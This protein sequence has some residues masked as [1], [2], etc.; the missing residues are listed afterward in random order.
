[1]PSISTGSVIKK[2]KNFI[3]AHETAS[4]PMT[5][6]TLTKGGKCYNFVGDDYRQF[7]EKY[8]AVLQSGAELDLHFVEKPNPVALFL[9]DVD[10]DQKGSKRQYKQK[11]IKQIIEETNSFLIENFLVTKHQLTTFVTE[12]DHSTKRDNNNYYKDGFHIYYPYL[13]MNEKHRYFVMDHLNDLM[14]ENVFLDGIEYIGDE[15]KIFD[16]S[17]IKSNGIVMIGSK[18]QGGQYY[19]LTHVYDSQ[20]QKLTTDEYDTEELVYL[21]SNQQYDIDAGISIVDDE[22]VI[23]KVDEIYKQYSGGNKK[24]K[25]KTGDHDERSTASSNSK[26]KIKKKTSVAQSRDIEMAKAL[27]KILSKKRAHDYVSWRRVGFALRA[28]DESLYD[29]FVEFSKR[30]MAKYREGKITCETIWETAAGFTQFYS[31]GTLRHWARTDNPKEYNKIIRKMYDSLFGRAETNKHVDIAEVVYALYRDRFVCI[32]IVKKKWYEFQDHKWVFVQS[33]YT[34]EELISSEVRDMMTMYCSEKLKQSLNNEDG[35]D[36]DVE[37]RK[38]QKL[39]RLNENLGDVKFRENVVRACSNKFFDATFQAKL[40]TNVYLVG[41]TNGVYDL[42]DMCFRDGLPTDYISKT[43]GYDW[44]EYEEDDEVFDK[45]HKYFSEV[46]IEEDMRTYL[47]TFIAKTLRG[48]PDSKLHMWTGGGGNGK[49]VTVDLIKHLLGD[50][51]GVVPVTLLTR[52]RGQ[53]SGPTPELADKFGKRFLIIQEPEHND[54]VF[55][56]QMK[57]YTGKDMI[58]A[59]PMYGDPFYYVPQF[60]MVLTCNNLPYIPATD[61]GTWRRLRVTPFESEFVDKPKKPNQFMKDEELQEDFPNWRQPLMWLIINKFYPI[62]AEGIDG[63][64]YK[65]FEPE[66]VTQFTNNYKLDSDVY[67]EFLEDNISKT[68][69]PNDTEP[70]PFLFQMFRDWY[71]GSYSEK[72]PAK[73]NFISYLK[74]NDYKIDAKGHKLIGYKYALSPN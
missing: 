63:K 68:D 73:K 25:K 36:R 74:K 28:I 55:V 6:T 53:S 17:I 5:H 59:R 7:L 18:K 34:L 54:V 29:D 15:E 27:C 26:I 58:M 23:E 56:G 57:E 47:M 9:I 33:A 46:Q 3:E 1:M 72:P 66:K 61:N 32:D 11:H 60:T 39:M 8:V 12:K 45:I 40:D 70:I 35:F 31:I 52:K 14:K 13:P 37:H 71:T 16:K 19:N 30:D 67:A 4:Q 24:K 43:V 21:L 2:F 22:T 51:F 69:D 48:V 65:I 62:Y 42:K 64:K 38:Y 49:S 20:L 44:Q 41:F 50:Y 10:Y